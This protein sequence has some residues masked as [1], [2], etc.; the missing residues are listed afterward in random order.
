[1]KVRSLIVATGLLAV[2]CLC[3]CSSEKTPTAQQQERGLIGKW[4]DKAD[5]EFRMEVQFYEDGK[6]ILKLQEPGSN[7]GAT[8][9][10]TFWFE[11]D[12]KGDELTVE[13][14]GAEKDGFK[15]TPPP[16]EKSTIRWQD[17]GG[18]FIEKWN[19]KGGFHKTQ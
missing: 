11:W 1:M 15:L 3:G 12:L 17:D 9:R 4:Q 10:T 16:F 19:P 13:Y 5:A 14:S 6:G 7:R 18:V 2:L 8:V